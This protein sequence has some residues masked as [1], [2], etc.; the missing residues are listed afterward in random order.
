MLGDIAMEQHPVELCIDPCAGAGADSLESS[1][2]TYESIMQSLHE[3]LNSANSANSANRANSPNANFD[4]DFA[5]FDF[6]NMDCA[7]A[8][9]FDYEMNY[10]MKQL[11][12]IAGYY[13][14]KCK[15]RKADMIQDIVLFETDDKNGDAVGRRKRLFHYMDTLKNDEYLKSYVIM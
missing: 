5:E 3:E 14:L 7:T 11:K 2:S 9:S 15:T 4:A 10:T 8:I 13:G 6:F 12:H 1:A